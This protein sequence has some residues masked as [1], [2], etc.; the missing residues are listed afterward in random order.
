M[1]ISDVDQVEIVRKTRK[2]FEETGRVP[3]IRE[4]D[5][6]ASRT[7]ITLLDLANKMMET[8]WEDL[9][10]EEKNLRGFFTGN[11]EILFAITM[12]TE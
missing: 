6:R 1:A 9:T 10:D 11:A 2:M 7:D 5:P 3:R 4:I 8:D 12:A